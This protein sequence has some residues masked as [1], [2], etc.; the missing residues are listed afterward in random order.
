MAIK[1]EDVNVIVSK[2]GKDNKD[3][4]STSVQ[5]ALLSK[6][7]EVLTAHLKTNGEDAPAR[8]S[9][10]MLVGK[11]H[12]LLDYLARNDREAYLKLIEQLGLRK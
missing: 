5:I 10:M 9:L 4:G 7:I 6:R 3:T 1:K 12:G 8:R 11:R 2:F